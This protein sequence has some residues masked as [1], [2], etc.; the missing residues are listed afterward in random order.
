MQLARFKTIAEELRIPSLFPASVVSVRIYRK[1]DTFWY[2]ESNSQITEEKLLADLNR[3]LSTKQ[4]WRPRRACQAFFPV[5]SLNAVIL[6][7]SNTPPQKRTRAILN[8]KIETCIKHANDAFDAS[9]DPLTGALNPKSID[10]ALQT[11]VSKSVVATAITPSMTV[12]LFESNQIAVCAFDL[13]HF[14]QINDSYGHDYGDIIL[15]C[16]VQRVQNKIDELRRKYSG[17]SLD[18]GRSGGEEF[19]AIVGGTVEET[20]IQDIAESI[21]ICVSSNELPTEKEWNSIPVEKKL[22][23][24]DLPH[25]SERKI[26]VSVGVSSIM[27]PLANADEKVWGVNLKREADASLY[28]A[29]AG[30][31]DTVRYFSKIRDQ[32]GMVIEHHPTT[33]VVVIDIGKNVDV[34]P[35]HEFLVFHPDFTGK[36]PFIQSDGR[37]RKCLGNYPRHWTGRIIVTDAQKEISFCTVEETKQLERFHPGSVLEF[38]P[39]GSIGH[40]ITRSNSQAIFDTNRLTDPVSFEAAVKSTMVSDEKFIVAVISML[41]SSETERSRGTAFTNRE[42]AFCISEISI[43]YALPAQISQIAPTMIAVMLQDQDFQH[44]HTT[45][46]TLVEHC[47]NHSAGVARFGAGIYFKQASKIPGDASK[48]SQ[49]FSLDYARYAAMYLAYDKAQNVQAFTA[50]TA[51]DS[52]YFMRSN[53]RYVDALSDYRRFTKLGLDYAPLHNHAALCHFEIGATNWDEAL[54]AINRACELDPKQLFFLANLGVISYRSG[55]KVAAH[56]AFVKIF[57][58]DNNFALPEAYFPF[59]AL[60][61]YAQFEAHP[62]EESRIFALNLLQDTISKAKAIGGTNW[63]GEAHSA[64]ANLLAPSI[65]R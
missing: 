37:S 22:S 38:I 17:I 21:R 19:L 42:L 5:E 63:I 23:G 25:V 49:E 1:S 26:T 35:G 30:G 2:D 58:I 46:K 14:K 13:D 27:T 15:I 47:T 48:L 40:L 65:T 11:L 51:S 12:S 57:E 44:A 45:I 64:I 31:R 55:D 3:S 33:N 61:A 36:R 18:F 50:T 20:V 60:S 59:R 10:T 41:N 43:A 32:C 29:K 52:I 24:F 62:S 7:V 39:V 53:G 28:R 54:H 56:N 6:I 34:Q 16:F 4:N 9:H 8:A